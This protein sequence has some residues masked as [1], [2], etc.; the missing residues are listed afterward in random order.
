M[1]LKEKHTN[2]FGHEPQITVNV[3]G[4]I[5]F[6]GEFAEYCDGY[7]LCG[8]GWTDLTVCVSQRDDNIVK[9]FNTFTGDHK[10]FALS[11]VKYRKEDR[12]GNYIKGIIY[13]VLQIRKQITGF[14]ITLE[15]SV[16]AGDGT[17]VS[18]AVGVGLMMALNEILGLGLDRKS[19]AAACYKSSYQFCN[20]IASHAVILTMLFAEK[21]KL[22]FYDVKKQEYKLLDNPFANG[23]NCALLIDSN[24]PAIAM[25]EEL[26]HHHAKVKSSIGRLRN[27]YP[28]GSLR[29]YP[30]SDISDRI[31]PLDEESRRVCSY[32]LD[33]LHTTALVDRLFKIKDAF[34]IGKAVGKIGKGLRDTLELSC[35]ELDWLMKRASEVAGCSGSATVFT[36]DSGFVLLI[37]SNTA[38]QS[39]LDKLE[40]YEHIFGFKAKAQIYEPGP[41]AQIV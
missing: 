38:V 21:D 41:C 19:I 7:A 9:I 27:S 40:N 36:G 23:Q 22:L 1:D 8:T 18:S 2:E 35:P 30:I 20:E 34:Q 39:Y 24:I 12:W 16:L 13:E 33:E 31:T 6:L 26:V 3:P 25:R 4:A 10:K 17:L 5:T 29:D 37:I 15:G 11:G 14:D 28:H 32:V